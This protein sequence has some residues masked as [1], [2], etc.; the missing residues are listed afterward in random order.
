MQRLHA[1][2]YP[3]IVYQTVKNNFLVVRI[4]MKEFPRRVKDIFFVTYGGKLTARRF[5]TLTN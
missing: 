4:L 1:G 3:W 5:I 2:K